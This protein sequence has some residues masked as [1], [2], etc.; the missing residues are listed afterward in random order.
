MLDAMK[1]NGLDDLDYKILK[2]LER[3]GRRSFAEIGRELNLSRTAVRERVNQMMQ[4]KVIERFSVI[5]NPRAVGLNFSV[6]FEIECNPAQLLDVAAV[7]AK[8]EYILSCNQ[9]TGKSTLHA[10]AALRDKEHL[11]SFL[12]E[13]I[14]ALPG[15]RS[16]NSLLLLRGL[17]PKS[18]GIKIN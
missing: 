12:T 13:V 1:A 15:T 6:F 3:Y 8:N 18:G 10:H 2:I 17:K 11:E 16:V 7:L 9:M 14:Y 5:I 4:E